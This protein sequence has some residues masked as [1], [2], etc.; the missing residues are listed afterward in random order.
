MGKKHIKARKLVFQARL[1]ELNDLLLEDHHPSI[2][3]SGRCP[4][5]MS[6]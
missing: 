4:A 2:D 5:Q 3:E 6:P 1:V